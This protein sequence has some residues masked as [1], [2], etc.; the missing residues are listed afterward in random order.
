MSRSSAALALT[1]ATLVSVPATSARADDLRTDLGSRVDGDAAAGRSYFAPTALT[2]AEGS[3]AVSVRAPLYPAIAGSLSYAVTDNFEAFVGGG[4][5]IVIE[6]ESSNPNRLLGGGFKVQ[7][8]RTPRAA[9]ALSASVY[10]RPAYFHTDP[11]DDGWHVDA[12][13]LGAFGGVATACL[14]D[15]CAVIASAHAHVLPEIAGGDQTRLWGGGSLVA[16]RGKSRLV[17][18]ATAGTDDGELGFLGYAGYRAARRSVSFDAGVL[19]AA[20]VSEVI[21]WPTLGLSVGF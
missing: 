6:D 1:I 19:V 21:P 3:G 20:S 14:D 4:A 7:A 10:R 15:R 8:L 16:G 5:A 2:G 13:V 9:L 12:L 18:D 11:F 17:L